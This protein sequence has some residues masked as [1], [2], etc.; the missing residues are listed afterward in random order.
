M[1]CGKRK[2]C[3]S[4]SDGYSCPLCPKSGPGPCS[5]E[6]RSDGG[7]ATRGAGVGPQRAHPCEN[8]VGR[9]DRR[10][11]YPTNPGHRVRCQAPP[12]A[13]LCAI[14]RS[15]VPVPESL[16]DSEHA[17]HPV[18]ASHGTVPALSDASDRSLVRTSLAEVLALSSL[19]LLQWAFVNNGIP[20]QSIPVKPLAVPV[21]AARSL[22]VPVTSLRA[23]SSLQASLQ[24]PCGVLCPLPTPSL[25]KTVGFLP[26]RFHRPVFRIPA[27]F[28]ADSSLNASLRVSVRRTSL[29]G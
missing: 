26:C 28:L 24:R 22:V 10:Y 5:P 23:P 20:C 16:S 11:Q 14:P 27:G 25:A 18:L 2:S 8:L 15:L 19:T 7:A 3:G 6:T 13:Y 29:L 1:P 9:K 12:W 4:C 17:A 21:R